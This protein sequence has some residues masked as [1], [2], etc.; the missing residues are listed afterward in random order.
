M[1]PPLQPLLLPLMAPPVARHVMNAVS[2]GSSLATA[3]YDS[4][5]EAAMKISAL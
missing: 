2:A 4:A 1:P 5:R 3:G